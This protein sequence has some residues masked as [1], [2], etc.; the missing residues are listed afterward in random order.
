MNK[1]LTEI[2]DFNETERQALMASVKDLSQEQLNFKPSADQWSIGEVLR[3]LSILEGRVS[4]LLGKKLQEATAAGIGPDLTD[5]S[6]LNC[7]DQ[8][9]IAAPDIKVRAP[10]VVAPEYG[11]D[12]QALLDAL[13]ESR[14]ML[15]TA[16]NAISQ[17][18][19]TQLTFPHPFFGQLNLYQWTLAVGKHEHRH[20]IQIANIKSASGYPVSSSATIA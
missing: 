11:M 9:P 14:K 8:F 19:L 3:H 10:E 17:V 2:V 7:L 18:D 13:I 5:E 1:K 15:L 16:I 12:K 20:C 6:V 4:M